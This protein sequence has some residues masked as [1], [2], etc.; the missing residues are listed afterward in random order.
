MIAYL[1][2]RNPSV[3]AIAGKLRAPRRRDIRVFRKSLTTGACSWSA[4]AFATLPNPQEYSISMAR[5]ASTLQ[6]HNRSFHTVTFVI[7]DLVWNLAPTSR[8]ANSSKSNFLPPP[9]LMNPFLELQ[10]HSFGVGRR[11]GIFE[12]K[13]FK[14][15]GEQYLE[16][17]KISDLGAIDRAGFAKKLE[18]HHRTAFSRG[19]D[20]FME[21]ARP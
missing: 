11:D 7:H 16:M 5:P 14:K 20:G 2:K 8:S 19:T 15:L 3:P 21:W 6:S 9:E 13:Q 17:L 18:R 4:I 1:Q 10:A 12:S